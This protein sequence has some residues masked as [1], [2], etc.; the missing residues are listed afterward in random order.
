MKKKIEW[1]N[2]EENNNFIILNKSYKFWSVKKALK[3]FI[4]EN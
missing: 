1:I 4:N 2:S 3:Y